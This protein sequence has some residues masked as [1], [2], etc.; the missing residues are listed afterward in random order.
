MD[1]IDG[2]EFPWYKY[3]IENDGGLGQK[4]VGEVERLRDGQRRW[5]SAKEVEDGKWER[6]A[7]Y[8]MNVWV[9]G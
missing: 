2:K 8:R 9:K 7:G 5:S 4:R 3:K 1:E 6:E